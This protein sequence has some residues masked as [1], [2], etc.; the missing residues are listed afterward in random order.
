MAAAEGNLEV[1]QLLVKY[2]YRYLVS[3]KGER[4]TARQ[5]ERERESETQKRERE[6]E[7]LEMEVVTARA[8]GEWKA[9]LRNRFLSKEREGER[10]ARETH[11]IVVSLLAPP[12][13]S[14]PAPPDTI[15]TCSSIPIPSVLSLFTSPPAP[16][17]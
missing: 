2:G 10:R 12:P 5:R 1:V 11:S 16:D 14:S 3:H 9:S 17:T 15:T 6:G 13:L 8:C 4:E 7:E